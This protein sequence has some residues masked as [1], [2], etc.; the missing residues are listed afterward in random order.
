MIFLRYL[1]K[2]DNVVLEVLL[3]A[4]GMSELDLTISD[5]GG[6]RAYTEVAFENTAFYTG[7]TVGGDGTPTPDLEFDLVPGSNPPLGEWLRLAEFSQDTPGSFDPLMTIAKLEDAL[8]ADVSGAAVIVPFSHISPSAAQ[9]AEG[10][11]L[12]SM[13]ATLG[14]SSLDALGKRHMQPYEPSAPIGPQGIPDAPV[15]NAFLNYD[16]IQAL[17]RV[18]LLSRGS[19]PIVDQILLPEAGKRMAGFPL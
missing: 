19:G 18:G 13:L 15:V 8:G 16:E 2:R 17:I 9:L 11:L 7:V 12:D 14:L 3:D 6:V 4:G 5:A 10:D 1:Q